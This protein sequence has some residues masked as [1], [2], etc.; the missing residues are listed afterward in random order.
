MWNFINNFDEN[1]EGVKIPNRDYNRIFIAIGQFFGC[2]ALAFDSVFR[3]KYNQAIQYKKPYSDKQQITR[4]VE[5]HGKNERTTKQRHNTYQYV[6]K[7][8]IDV[9]LFEQFH[10]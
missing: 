10:N 3:R 5:K 2:D 4:R 1:G 7:Y 6:E 8:V 9:K